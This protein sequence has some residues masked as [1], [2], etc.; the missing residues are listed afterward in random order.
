[1]SHTSHIAP[2]SL[3]SL[4]SVR[5][6]MSPRSPRSPLSFSSGEGS[7]EGAPGSWRGSPSFAAQNWG[8]AQRPI[9]DSLFK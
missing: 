2:M 5:S 1:M 8:S 3:M 6:F 9:I 4:M 7:G